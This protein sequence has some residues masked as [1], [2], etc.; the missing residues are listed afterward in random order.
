M[1][2][3]FISCVHVSVS[4]SQELRIRYQKDY[5]ISNPVV[6]FSAESTFFIRVVSDELNQNEVSPCN[7]RDTDISEKTFFLPENPELSLS[8]NF[9]KGSFEILFDLGESDIKNDFFPVLNAFA[10]TYKKDGPLVI[11]GYTCPLGT[12][13]LNQ[14]LGQRRAE[15]LK[16]FFEKKGFLHIEAKGKEG[17]YKSENPDL[18]HLNRRAEITYNINF[19]KE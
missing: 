6:S 17:F 9:F 1:G 16:A 12:K 19:V 3:F 11:E 8:Q 15:K 4:F 14:T 10:R 2:L 5:K 13:T 18:F 7:L